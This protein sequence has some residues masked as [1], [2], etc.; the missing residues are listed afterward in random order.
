MSL[1]MNTTLPTPYLI[2]TGCR[3]QFARL[4]L[5]AKEWQD[6]WLRRAGQAARWPAIPGGPSPTRRR[7]ARAGRANWPDTRWKR[8]RGWRPRR[9]AF[10]PETPPRAV[11]TGGRAQ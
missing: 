4:T 3:L 6:R 11:S 1:R 10:R 7:R 5:R 2:V 9:E 8:A